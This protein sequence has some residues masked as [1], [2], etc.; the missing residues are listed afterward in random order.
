MNI[1]NKLLKKFSM[2]E[3]LL[4]DLLQCSDSTKLLILETIKKCLDDLKNEFVTVNQR[5]GSSTP[6]IKQLM[7]EFN[8]YDPDDK[9]YLNNMLE[10]HVINRLNNPDSYTLAPPGLDRSPDDK[11]KNSSN[12]VSDTVTKRKSRRN[13]TKINKD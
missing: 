2:I 4:G 3:D 6:E 9:G 10:A 1:T 11:T 5:I 7:A 12:L 13:K 8:F